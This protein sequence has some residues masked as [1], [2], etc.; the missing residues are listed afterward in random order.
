MYMENLKAE[1]KTEV[2]REREREREGSIYIFSPCFL[3]F[4]LA[5]LSI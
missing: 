2:G 5:K 4:L 1:Q 3:Y